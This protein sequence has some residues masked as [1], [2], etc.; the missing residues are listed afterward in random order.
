VIDMPVETLGKPAGSV[1]KCHFMSRTYLKA[2]ILVSTGN[3]RD[4]H[5]PT[6]M[7]RIVL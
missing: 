1:M 6:S 5:T 3:S 7:Y 4:V 2:V